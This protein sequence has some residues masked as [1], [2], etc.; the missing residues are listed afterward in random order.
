MGIAGVRRFQRQL[1]SDPT[2]RVKFSRCVDL[3]I[4][5]GCRHVQTNF[6]VPLP[7]TERRFRPPPDQLSPEAHIRR[8][9]KQ[10]AGQRKQIQA[11]TPQKPL[12]FMPRMPLG[13]HS[14][15]GIQGQG[16]NLG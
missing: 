4:S 2:G 5:K 8:V 1:P 9:K 13:G 10:Q 16:R 6:F 12:A 15:C 7:G 3:V 14:N 11:R